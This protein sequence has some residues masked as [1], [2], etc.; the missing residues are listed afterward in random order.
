MKCNI[1]L[2]YLP[3]IIAATCLAPVMPIIAAPQSP[4]VVA[5]ATTAYNTYMRRGYSATAK[6]DYRNALVN[7]RR[8]LR[9]RPG[10]SYATAAVNNVST[11]ARRGSSKAIFIASN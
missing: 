5:Q 4:T 1:W 8:A 3:A 11:Y 2:K 6:R 10:D 7:F 9:V